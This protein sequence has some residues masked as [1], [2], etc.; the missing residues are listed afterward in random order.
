MLANGIL[1]A[2]V[3]RNTKYPKSYTDMLFPQLEH[4]YGMAW[5]PYMRYIMNN[6]SDVISM[7]RRTQEK[8]DS[9]ANLTQRERIWSTMAAI[10]LTGGAIAHS[11]GLHDINVERVA[12]WVAG[13]MFDSSKNITQSSSTT[14]EHIAAYMAENYTNMLMLLS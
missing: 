1:I 11:L 10:G 13:H 5:L 7:L 9:A 8:T 12:R 4:N 6:Q 3:Q 14:E 2:G